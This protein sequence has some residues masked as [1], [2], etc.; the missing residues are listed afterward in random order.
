MVK[1]FFTESINFHE[2][3]FFA[4][5]LPRSDESFKNDD[6]ISEWLKWE[7]IFERAKQGDFSRTPELIDLLGTMNLTLDSAITKLLGFAGSSTALDTAVAILEGEDT[8][9]HIY[10]C[11]ALLISGDLRYV[12]RVVNSY[13]RLERAGW[14]ELEMIPVL[15]RRT[16][17]DPI[18]SFNDNVPIPEFEAPVL[19]RCQELVRHYESEKVCIFQGQKKSPVRFARELHRCATKSKL[20]ALAPLRGQ[21]E[22][23]TGIDCSRF[24]DAS[25]TT[26]MLEIAAVAEEFLELPNAERF[27][28]GSRYFFGH[29][30]SD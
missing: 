20:S 14:R 19:A 24:F 5:A 10:L 1:S 15:L 8:I 11:Q 16:L 4:E 25:R 26:R 30:I 27:V 22:A 21:F 2:R 17:A 3:G 12:P 18:G 9:E 13:V 29:R 23:F 28:E 7:D 6:F